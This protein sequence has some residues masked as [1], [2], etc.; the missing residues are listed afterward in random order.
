VSSTTDGFT[1]TITVCDLHENRLRIVQKI[2]I[3]LEYFITGILD[4]SRKIQRKSDENEG[5]IS[6]ASFLK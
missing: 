4:K 1:S 3:D 6:N 2:K 5:A